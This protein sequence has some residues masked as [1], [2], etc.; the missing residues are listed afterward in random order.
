[1]FIVASA[2]IGPPRRRPPRVRGLARRRVVRSLA[3]FGNAVADGRS[4][5]RRARARGRGGAWTARAPLLRRR[6]RR[7]PGDAQRPAHPVG[8]GVWETHNAG[9]TWEPIFDAQPAASIGALAIAPSDPRVLYVGTGES[10]MRSDI[11][12]GNGMY[13][14]GD[15]GRTWTRIG[16]EATRQIA[17]I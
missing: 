6:P 4:V 14:S 16:L 12:Y 9:R 5:S 15:G 17:R 11:S 7:P 8:G 1:V 3:L 2:P 13:R 10:D